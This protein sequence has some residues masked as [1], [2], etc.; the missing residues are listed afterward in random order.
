M[1]RYIERG[2]HWAV[3]VCHQLSGARLWTRESVAN[4]IDL[5]SI[6][7]RGI[8]QFVCLQNNTAGVERSA[9]TSRED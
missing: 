6:L 4:V 8:I 2:S 5:C 1:W 9:P 3:L 7:C